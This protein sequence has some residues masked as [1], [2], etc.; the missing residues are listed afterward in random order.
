MQNETLIT[1][2]EKQLEQSEVDFVETPVILTYNGFIGTTP[3]PD[4]HA[5]IK[6]QSGFGTM[7]QKTSLQ[8]LEVLF[9]THDGRFL[10]GD[11]I[12]LS[13]ECYRHQYASNV[14]TLSG[15]TCIMVPEAQVVACLKKNGAYW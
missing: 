10:A 13:A 6:V 12:Y 5:K 7:E 11:K 9:D 4:M 8:E 2:N 1:L 14:L 15:K 3:F